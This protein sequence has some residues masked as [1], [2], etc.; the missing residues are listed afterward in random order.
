MQVCSS[1][2]MAA[3]LYLSSNTVPRMISCF[4]HVHVDQCHPFYSVLT[5]VVEPNYMQTIVL[6]WL[7]KNKNLCQ[8]DMM[9]GVCV[10]VRKILKVALWGSDHDLHVKQSTVA[11]Y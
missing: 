3:L 5:T 9:T 4:E 10:C 1:V 7:M 6:S 11:N 2:T 8:F